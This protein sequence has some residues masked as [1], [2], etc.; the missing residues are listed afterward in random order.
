ML[1]YDRETAP[2]D[3]TP[4]RT[5]Q[6]PQLCIQLNVPAEL[7]S[8]VG[9]WKFY[10]WLRLFGTPLYGANGGGVEQILG[11]WYAGTAPRALYPIPN[12]YERLV[13]PNQEFWST[14]ST[15]LENFF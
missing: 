2:D 1:K 12:S 3:S 4:T 5:A 10:P 11:Y 15:F 8:F 13:Y 7:P 9:G 14:V 6:V